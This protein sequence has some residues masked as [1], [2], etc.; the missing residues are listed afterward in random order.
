MLRRRIVRSPPRALLLAPLLLAGLAALAVSAPA[1]AETSAWATVSGGAL[2][3]KQAGSAYAPAATMAID[4]G[5]GTS[6]DARFIIGGFARLQPVF[7]SGADLDF[8]ARGASHGFQAGDWGFAIDAGTYLR[9]WGGQSF[10]F[11]GGA[12]LGLPLGFTVSLQTNAGTN[13]ALA[14]G[15]SAGLDFLRLTI[16]RQTLLQRW[17]NPSPAYKQSA[18]LP[19]LSF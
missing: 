17:K 4:F 19:G 15:G 13:G 8:L 2:A 1:R 5:V 12:S 6:P 16:Y 10:G 3:W 9:F 14:F 18:S 7:G 11:T